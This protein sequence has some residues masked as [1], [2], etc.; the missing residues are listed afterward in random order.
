MATFLTAALLL[1]QSTSIYALPFDTL[2]YPRQ[3]SLVDCLEADNIPITISAYAN[4]SEYQEPYNLRLA[5]QPT[6]I[7]LPETTEHVSKSVTCAA[8]AGVKVQAKSGG[9]SYGSYSSGGQ[10]GSLIVDLE[11]FNTVELDT[12][13]CL[14]VFSAQDFTNLRKSYFYRYCWWWCQARESCSG[15][16]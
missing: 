13:R 8:A 1:L 11:N 15:D 7:T 6:V 9:H 3:T 12:C 5:Y 10:D 16:L 14:Q 2:L 4:Y